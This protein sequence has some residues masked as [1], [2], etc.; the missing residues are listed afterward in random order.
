[1]ADD[2]RDDA[3]VTTKICTLLGQID[4]WKWNPAT[5]AVYLPTDVRIE[6]GSLSETA[7]KGVAVRLYNATDDAITGLALR[8]VQL[9]FRG[10]RGGIAHA[11]Q[12]A[13]AAFAHLQNLSRKEG[14]SGIRR[15]SISP[16]GADS[17]AR[18]GRTD[19]YLVTLDNPEAS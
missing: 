14:I 7:N 11:D 4:G 10:T 18:Q 9:R 2:S 5:D 8:W 3:A 17:S 15:L 19:N 16:Q 6:Y 13:S 1:V 12:L